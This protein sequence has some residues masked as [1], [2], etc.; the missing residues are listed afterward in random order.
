[1][2]K[3]IIAVILAGG[4]SSRMGTDKSSLPLY[5][6]TMLEHLISIYEPFFEVFVSGHPC[7]GIKCLYDEYSSAGPLAGL[8]S[9]FTS[10]DADNVFITATDMPGGSGKLATLLA[11]MIDGYD[12]CVIKRVSGDVEPSFAVY[13]RACFPFIK[14]IIETGRR[15]LVELLRQVNTRYVPEDELSG[16]DLDYILQ[17]INTP[18]DYE[19]FISQTS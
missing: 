16:F 10:T 18:A 3:K 9:A 2:E 11:D 17:N 7:N 12:A 5:N 4:K 15:S 13:S 8:S 6:T 14:P 19:R 1:M